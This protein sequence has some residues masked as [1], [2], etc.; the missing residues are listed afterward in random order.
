MGLTFTTLAAV[1][2]LNIR[3]SGGDEDPIT[4][5][6]VKL[7]GEV[8]GEV[9]AI[10]MG[11]D[12]PVE[13]LNT[14][15]DLP[16]D[17]RHFGIEAIH[18]WAEFENYT[19]TLGR[20][21]AFCKVKKIVWKPQGDRKADLTLTVSIEDPAAALVNYL[22]DSI[23]ADVRLSLEPPQELPLGPAAAE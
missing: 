16:G 3:K 8:P 2:H 12:N 14:F 13:F 4:A 15:W 20:L 10:P 22:V 18:S 11:S 19:V 9:L 1:Q 6:D 7:T 5:I 17:V 21:S 23:K